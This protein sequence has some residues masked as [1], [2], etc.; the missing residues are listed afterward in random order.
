MQWSLVVLIYN[1]QHDYERQL[2][3]WV[4]GSFSFYFFVSMI[5][6]AIHVFK[7]DQILKSKVADDTLIMCVHHSYNAT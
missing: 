6:F 1:N 4:Y 3:Q 7:V 2:H 5:I